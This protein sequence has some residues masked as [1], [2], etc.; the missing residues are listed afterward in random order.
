M[1]K[2]FGLTGGLA[3]GKSTVAAHLRRRGMPMIDAD[4]LARQVVAPGSDGLNEVVKAFGRDVA[5]GGELDRR[6]LGRRVFADPKA[7]ARLEGITHP[8]IR[9]Q[10]ARRV[11]ELAADGEPIAGY[12]VPLL[13]EKG[14]DA[15]LQPVILVALPGKLQLERALARG[16][17]ERS[18]VLARLAAQLPLS[19]K[20]NR[21]ACV[22]DNSGTLE[23]TFLQTDAA[24]AH[25]CK[26]F[27]EDP[28]RYPTRPS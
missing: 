23:R 4:T 13:F 21:A 24:L 22:I 1:T 17:L 26:T 7:L 2:T 18:E 10:F 8:R 12:E 6:R 25:V 3:S 28:R 15:E 19:D 5:P 27:G 9:M 11:S 20:L 14:L 16:G